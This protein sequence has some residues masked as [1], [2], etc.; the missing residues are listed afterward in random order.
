[1]ICP[2]CESEN[3]ADATFCLE[4]GTPLDEESLAEL[5][6]PA[7][8][9]APEAASF[10]LTRIIKPLRW[11]WP[12]RLVILLALIALSANWVGSSAQQADRDLYSSA[13]QAQAEHRWHTAARLFQQLDD[14]SYFDAAARLQQVQAQVNSF[15]DLYGKGSHA[16][17]QG[18]KVLAAYYYDRANQIEPDYYAV[19]ITLDRLRREN[20]RILYRVPEGAPSGASAGLYVMEADGGVALKIPESRADSVVLATSPDGRLIAFDDRHDGALHLYV[21]DTRSYDTIAVELPKAEGVDRNPE[22]SIDVALLNGGNNLLVIDGGHFT[23]SNNKPGQPSAALAYSV[24]LSNRQSSYIGLVDV[25]AYPGYYDK[26]VHYTDSMGDLHSYDPASDKS[27][28]AFTP[29]EHLYFMQLLT[30]DRILYATSASVTTT[31]YLASGGQW[32]TPRKLTELFA[33]ARPYGTLQ[34]EIFVSPNSERLFV[35]LR[36]RAKG[37][38]THLFDLSGP[39]E[40]KSLRDASF[41]ITDQLSLISFSD[42]GSSMLLKVLARPLDAQSPPR[43]SLIAMSENRVEFFFTYPY[44]DNDSSVTVEDARFLDEDDVYYVVSQNGFNREPTTGDIM[45]AQVNY[46]NTPIKLAAV[47]TNTLGNWQPVVMMPD[48]HTLVYAGNGGD[49]QGIYINDTDGKQPLK[50]MKDTVAFWRLG[51]Q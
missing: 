50:V 28:L 4:C 51:G 48:Q 41:P 44:L 3:R 29:D 35:T 36:S 39:G 17:A 2:Q 15:E 16:E 37:V 38:E 10:D 34:T 30:N 9:V 20:G 22:Q 6:A 33:N 18:Y 8:K 45:V 5:P 32:A 21:K 40:A 13:R 7:P 26:L 49:G 43:T 19:D 47:N 46:P 23:T 42:S 12:V 1:M 25:V 11:S 27:S 14:K 24:N 31:V